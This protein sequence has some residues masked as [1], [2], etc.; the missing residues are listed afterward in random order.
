MQI[1]TFWKILIKIIGLWILLS[2]VSLIPK[3]FST[4]SF[5]NGS[6]DTEG[7]LILWI[8]LLVAVIVYILIIRL[9]LFKTDWVIE[10]LQLEKNFTEERIDLNLKT[11]T[12]L[13]IAIIVMGG[14]ILVESLPSFCSE[15]F[16][17]FQ[18]KSLLRDYPDTIWLIYH[19]IKIIIGYLLLTNANKLANFI[20]KKAVEN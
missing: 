14:L 4:L 15:L 19:F 2:C 10:K 1:K 18:Q 12:I 5:T 11:S 13:T 6:L 8:V 7:L 3:F 17:F 9:F 16:D 20:E